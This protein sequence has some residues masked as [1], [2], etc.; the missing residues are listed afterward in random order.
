[1]KLKVP[2]RNAFIDNFFALKSGK[3]SGDDERPSF[4]TMRG[5]L[6]CLLTLTC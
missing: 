5:F 1:M 6:T 4:E 3:E 2:S